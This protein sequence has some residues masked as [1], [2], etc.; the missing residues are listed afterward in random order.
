VR[1]AF[2]GAPDE[3]GEQVQAFVGGLVERGLAGWAA[4]RKET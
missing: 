4:A 2:N 1:D 3:V